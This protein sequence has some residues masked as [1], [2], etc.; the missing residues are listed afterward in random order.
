MKLRLRSRVTPSIFSLDDTESLGDFGRKIGFGKKD[1]T[2]YKHHLAFGG[3][4]HE[5]IVGK[6]SEF[7]DAFRNLSET[8]LRIKIRGTDK[9]SGI[10]SKLMI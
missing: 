2:A 7:G 6:P 9:E 4:Q 3:I 10:I 5:V 8:G 1:R